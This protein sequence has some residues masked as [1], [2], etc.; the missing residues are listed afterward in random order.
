MIFYKL[1]FLTVPVKNVMMQKKKDGM[2]CRILNKTQCAPITW[3][4]LS[5]NEKQWVNT[6]CLCVYLC[7]YS[8]N[9]LLLKG[10]V[11]Y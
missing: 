1:V 11:D 4:V 8:H 7:V 5:G 2:I 3:L 10:P 6:L 9:I